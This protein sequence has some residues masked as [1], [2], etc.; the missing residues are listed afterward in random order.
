MRSGKNVVVLLLEP[1]SLTRALLV[2][3]LPECSVISANTAHQAVQIANDRHIDVVIT[4]LTLGGHSGLEF[5]YEFR[6][7][8]DWQ[9]IP[10]FVYSNVVVEPTVLR[11]RAWEQLGIRAYLQKS[12]TSINELKKAVKEAVS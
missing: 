6:T 10:V 1:D 2:E 8:P 12:K 7:Y 11:A 5:L 3:A 9:H 4:E